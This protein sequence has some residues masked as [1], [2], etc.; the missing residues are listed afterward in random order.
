ME[1]I[2][3]FT[4]SVT[5]NVTGQLYDGTFK[6]KTLLTRREQFN[7]DLKRREIVGGQPGDA[8]PTLQGEA[9]VLGQLF[10]RIVD[11]PGW[12]P[13]SSFGLDLRDSNVTDEMFRLALEAEQKAKESIRGKA[14]EALEKLSG[15]TAKA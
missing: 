13:Q 10:V 6:V 9:F 2:D 14:K 3:T 15:N 11:G 4:L 5:G 7:A 1:A 12:W 8:M